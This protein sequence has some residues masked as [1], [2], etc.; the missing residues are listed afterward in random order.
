MNQYDTKNSKNQ[1]LPNMKNLDINNSNNKQVNVNNTSLN[2]EKSL[3][4]SKNKNFV[5]S[6]GTTTL[7][8]ALKKKSKYK[9]EDE[10]EANESIDNSNSNNNDLSLSENNDL[11]DYSSN[12][13]K[14]DSLRKPKNHKDKAEKR[15]IGLI[16]KSLLDSK[17]QILPFKK[18]K[19][20]LEEEKEHA[21]LLNKKRQKQVQR[22][23]GYE[24]KLKNWKS[25][26]KT[27][28]KT[29]TKGIVKLFN[30]IYNIK[31]QVV[32]EHKQ[33]LV[34]REKKSKNFLMMHDLAAPIVNKT[35]KEDEN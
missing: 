19:L 14:Y 15:N 28:L 6:K 30:N 23:L 7:P 5:K 1:N 11:S 29:A 18:E 10:D 8:N 26:E 9:D 2:Q 31:R 27:L 32:E 35:F 33:E 3:I 24:G 21:S 4:N 25:N 13:D 20:I 22:K 12:S 17:K 16:A 34:E